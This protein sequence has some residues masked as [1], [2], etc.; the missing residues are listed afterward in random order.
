MDANLSKLVDDRLMS[1]PGFSIE[2]LMELAGYGVASAVL[3]Y[4]EKFQNLAENDK[5]VLIFCGPGN[6]GGD[7]LVA[8]RHLRHFGLLPTVVY[9]KRSKSVLF[10]NLTEQLVDLDIE[11]LDHAPNS[12]EYSNF[13]LA[14]DAL[15]GFSFQGPSREPYTSIIST[16]ASSR[17]PVFSVDIPS[18]WDVN[19]GDIHDTKFVPDAVISLTAPKLCMKDYAGVHY[20]GGRFVPPKLAA[21]LGLV[22]PDY[23]TNSKQLM[24]L[25]EG[26]TKKSDGEGMSNVTQK[27]VSVV[28]VTASSAEEARRLANALVQQK[29]VACVNIIPGVESIYEWQGKLESSQEVMLM[30]KT[31][32]SLVPA[33]AA[34]VKQLHS[35][36]LPEVLALDATGGSE[37]YLDWVR[38]NTVTKPMAIVSD[39]C[40]LSAMPPQSQKVSVCEKSA[41]KV[42]PVTG[43]VVAT[44]SAHQVAQ[45]S[46]VYDTVVG[47][48][49]T[50]SV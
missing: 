10:T 15:F 48:A 17:I 38:A 9:P 12:A 11:I 8:A 2:Q 1:A 43:E 27:P 33:V 45:E 7:G 26:S 44:Q 21:E 41:V 25:S 23:G 18:G 47:T 13:G 4:W 14:I 40:S 49:E 32:R 50:G 31:R 35:Y 46:L 36:D 5:N 28:Y 34:M 24:L 3:E 20:V 29:L 42:A 39:T 30:I 6:N 19:E 22:L 37:A 16:L